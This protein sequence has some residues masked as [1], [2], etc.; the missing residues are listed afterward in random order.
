MAHQLGLPNNLHT[1]SNLVATIVDILQSGR[2]NSHMV[3][4]IDTTSNAKTK[5]VKTSETVLTSYRVTVGKDIANLATTNTSLKVELD[6]KSLCREPGL[7]L[8][9]F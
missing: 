9:S 6:S 4:G 3:V 5:K 7:L 8:P 1:S 2:N